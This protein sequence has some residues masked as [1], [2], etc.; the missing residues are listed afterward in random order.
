MNIPK[1]QVIHG[2][3]ISIG[4]IFLAKLFSPMIMSIFTSLTDSKRAKTKSDNLEAMIAH[5]EAMLRRGAN[6]ASGLIN[7]DSLETA[8]KSKRK[9]KLEVELL[10]IDKLERLKEK[11]SSEDLED[12]QKI[13]SLF[14]SLQ[15]GE[16]K[17]LVDIKNKFNKKFGVSPEQRVFLN[18]LKSLIK[19][20]VLVA[21]KTKNLPVYQEIVNLLL[22]KTLLQSICLNDEFSKKLITELARKI[23]VSSSCVA[24]AVAAIL[25]KKE[26]EVYS[27]ILESTEV[28]QKLN[29]Q[30]L[31]VLISKSLLTEDKKYFISMK[32]LINNIASEASLFQ[33]L[34]PLPELTGKNDIKGAL[35][36]FNLAPDSTKEEVKKTY[37]KLSMLKHPDRLA[38]KGIP[39]SFEK[40]A[41]DNFTRI[42]SA[43]D[44][45]KNKDS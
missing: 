25:N 1:E 45:L 3:A 39:K 8:V 30:T 11:G 27:S 37:K 18:H 36:I 32:D 20:E 17:A 6:K 33:T 19:R 44:I 43:Y 15:W 16:G 10:Y 38:S 42:Q 2:I 34:S 21:R 41:H 26:Q 28:F 7:N 35:K 5:K 14:E 23:N 4:T 13:V 31:D 9:G 40:I 24:K 12:V 22:T 29:P